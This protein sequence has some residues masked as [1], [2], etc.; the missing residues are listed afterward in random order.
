MANYKLCNTDKL[1]AD[2]TIVADAIRAKGKTEDKLDFPADFKT[3]IEKI[4]TET[5]V[6]VQTKEGNISVFGGSGSADCGFKPDVVVI[7]VGTNAYDSIQNDP[8]F[9]FTASGRSSLSCSSIP[10]NSSY[11]IMNIKCNQNTSGFSV[12]MINIKSDWTTAAASG[13]FKYIAIKYT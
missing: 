8:A 11:N 6:K 1:D 4:E 9:A 5:G 3:A 12:N 7:K 13:S 2:L 10:N